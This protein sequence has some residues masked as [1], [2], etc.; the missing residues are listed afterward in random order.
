MRPELGPKSP[1]TWTKL[2][3]SSGQVGV[4]LAP[5]PLREDIQEA[6]QENT[7]I[8]L[9]RDIR[10]IRGYPKIPENHDI[11]E[12]SDIQY[13]EDIFKVISYGFYTISC[14]FYMIL[15]FLGKF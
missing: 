15:Y 5:A 7:K 2:A 8:E 11:R 1:P 4:M 14:G 9:G 6:N 12:K 10:K 3:P 13:M